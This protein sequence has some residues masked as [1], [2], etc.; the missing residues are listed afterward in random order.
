MEP[1]CYCSHCTVTKDIR[2]VANICNYLN[3]KEMCVAETL[4][5]SV[6]KSTM[7]NIL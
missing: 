4:K 3:V 5:E 1:E 6:L 2:Y 7:S